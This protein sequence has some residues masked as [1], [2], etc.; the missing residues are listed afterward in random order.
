MN[1]NLNH[2]V[3]MS[4]VLSI[5]I[6]FVVMEG[7]TFVLKAFNNECLDMHNFQVAQ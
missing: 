7:S 4:D 3:P 2:T 6:V 1:S 5:R